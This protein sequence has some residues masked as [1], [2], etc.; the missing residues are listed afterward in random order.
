MKV[1]S[2]IR[3]YSSETE[4]IDGN[5]M[6]QGDVARKSI[7]T[8]GRIAMKLREAEFSLG[9]FD[10]LYLN[11][12][13]CL[14]EGE[15]RPAG[16]SVDRYHPWY[17]YYDVGV[18][19]EQYARL[20]SEEGLMEAVDAIERT[21]L[22]YF[23]P[24]QAAEELVRSAVSEAVAQGSSML[25]KYKEKKSAKAKAEIFLRLTDNGQYW[26]LLRVTDT[27]GREL[28]RENLPERGD[29]MMLGDIQMSS[30]RVTVKPKK[31]AIASCLE[32]QPLTFDIG[33]NAEARGRELHQEAATN[34][35]MRI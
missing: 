12:T 8:A 20:E 28:L 25:M 4:N 7:L 3:L 34:E 27:E 16:R 5:G 35:E 18:S 23:A 33:Q 30:K 6:P 26:P 22:R 10:H 14:P 2:D 1:I 15:I 31:N 19:Q 11:F 24:D 21:L 9:D 32:L 29:F 17:R 13:V